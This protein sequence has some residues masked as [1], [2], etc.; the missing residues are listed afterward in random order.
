M[1]YTALIAARLRLSLNHIKKVDFV[2][3]SKPG[4]LTLKTVEHF[5]R[6]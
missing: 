2:V 6:D 3:I 1:G 5:S 4:D